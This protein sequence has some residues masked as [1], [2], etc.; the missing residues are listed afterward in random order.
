MGQESGHSLC[1]CS[2]QGATGCNHGWQRC[3]LSGGLIGGE[4]QL[5]HSFTLL[6]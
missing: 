4:N 5:S 6:P 3:I 2:V 1:G